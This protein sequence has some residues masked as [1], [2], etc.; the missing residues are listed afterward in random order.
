MSIHLHPS[1]AS[2]GAA[3]PA[4]RCRPKQLPLL[5][6][7]VGVSRICLAQSAGADAGGVTVLAPVAVNAARET[8]VTPV[9][10]VVAHVTRTATKTD[11]PISE[12]PQAVSVVTRDQM[13]QQNV[14]SVG[15]GLRY[16]SGVYA[17]SRIGGVLESVFLRGFGGFAAAATSPQFLDGLP[18]PMGIS[19]AAPVIDP[20]VLQRIEV[21]HGPASVLYGQASP[22]GIVNLTSKLPTAKPYHELAVETGSRGRAQGSLDFGGPLT[23]DGVWAYRLNA[24]ARRDD[25]QTDH[26][27]EQRIVVAPTLQWKP[28]ASTKLTAFGLYQNDPANTFPGWLPAAGTLTAGPAGRIPTRFFPGEPDFDGYDRRQ[29]LLGYAFEHRFDDTWTIR[30]NVRYTHLGVDFR[31]VA[32]DF[33]SPFGA[34]PGVLNRDASW[35]REQV[36][37]VTVDQ[38]VEARLRTGPLRHTVLAGLAWDHENA[39]ITASGYGLAPSIDYLNPS[40]GLPLALPAVAQRSR[41]REDR[42][43]V[44]VQDQIRVGR[45]A[46]TLGGRQD[47][48]RTT[49]DDE[50]GGSANRQS[51]RAF[52]GRVGGVY[53]FDNGL[54]P[55]ASYS[56]SF[57]PTLGTDF[58]GQPFVPT[59]AKQSEIGVRYEPPGWNAAITLA[60]FDIDERNVIVMDPDHPFSN[61]QQGQ[62]RSRGIEV[63]AHAK[64]MDRLDAIVAYTWLDTIDTEDSNAA[65]VGK[66][67][68]AV[69]RQMASV[70]LN[71]ATPVG[72]TLGGGLRYVGRSAGDTANTF[73]V[74]AVTLVDLALG[75]DLRAWRPALKGW[76]AAAHVNNLFDR[77]YVSSCF[78]A[79]GCFYGQRRSVTGSLT[80]Q[81]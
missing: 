27:K 21:L 76:R 47:W 49:T 11:T 31:G 62:V 81:W 34:T 9:A 61:I 29:Y 37:S 5:L 30:Q 19:W 67:L 71:Y 35:S 54:S 64:L 80:Y 45:W 42:L 74:P 33:S 25:E 59:R 73:D 43:G 10:G 65:S 22:G 24:M 46:F 2:A 8:G 53:E 17:D 68:P 44:Y 38:Q 16:T 52:T 55:Y 14:H 48:T 40:Y 77:T 12:I 56:T 3:L 60:G 51:N 78:S 13:D 69:P 23:D 79:G 32:I 63:E 70:W 72:L 6:A 20:S 58:G 66:R 75:Y 18:L 1:P 28:D 36:N 41:Q 50:L 39:D 7:L 57:Q 4:L 15:D 26:G